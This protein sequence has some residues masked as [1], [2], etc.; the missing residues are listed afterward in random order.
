MLGHFGFNK[1]HG[2]LRTSFYSP[3]MC[4]NLQNTYVKEQPFY[5]V[6][7]YILFQYWINVE[8][9]LQLTSSDHYPPT[10]DVTPSSPSWTDWEV[11]SNSFHL[12]RPMA[13]E[14]AMIFFD[15]CIVKMVFLSRL[16]PIGTN[17]SPQ[18][19][20]HVSTESPA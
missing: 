18:N 10:A 20:G 7:P 1:S 2:S 13:E 3:K 15:E 8:T 17:S 4:H 14:L 6:A 9:Q 5:Q 11:T 12:K 16:Y 19:S